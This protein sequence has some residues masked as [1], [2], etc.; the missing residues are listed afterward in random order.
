MDLSKLQVLIM[1]QL[2]TVPESQIKVDI[3]ICNHFQHTVTIQTWD[4]PLDP[5]CALLGILDVLDR[6]TN[7]PLPID[8]VVF[9][10]QMPPPPE[11][12]VQI[13]SGGE[14]TNSV[15]IPLIQFDLNHEY[16]IEAKGAWKA[17]WSDAKD[18]ID[19]SILSSLADASTGEYVSN[20]VTIKS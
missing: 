10:R 4:S 9:S 14:C 11:S 6:D 7:T 18:K 12:F 5:K 17:V 13:E 1:A 2:L 15:L 8:R 19:A 16:R 3:T 20:V